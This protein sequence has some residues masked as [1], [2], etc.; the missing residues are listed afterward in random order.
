MLLRGAAESIG[1]DLRRAERGPPAGGSGSHPLFHH[2]GHQRHLRTQGAAAGPDHRRQGARSSGTSG[3]TRSRSVRSAG[4]R[5]GGLP[6]HRGGHRHR[7]RHRSRQGDQPAHRGRSQPPGGE[8]RRNGFP[9]PGN[10]LQ[11]GCAAQ[12]P[13]PSAGRRAGA[14]RQRSDHR[15][16]RGPPHL[17]GADQL[18]PA[19]GDGGL[20]VQ[21]GKP[22]ARLPHQEPAADL[23]QRRRRLAGGQ[24]RGDQDLQ[25]RPPRR[26]GRHEDLRQA[27]QHGRC[28]GHRRGRHDHRHRPVSRRQGGRSAARPRGRD[29]RVLPAVRNHERGRRRQLHLQ[30]GEQAHP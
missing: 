4:G 6:R 11:E 13:A 9:R 22:P 7:C 16:G 2:P 25:L 8:L 5:P 30:G 19:P 26:H 12:I 10:P 17:D 20:P 18:L 23:P 24:D 28:G 3:R 27:L 15:P 29:Q 14:L 21:C 1:G